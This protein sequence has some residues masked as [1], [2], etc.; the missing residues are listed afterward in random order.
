MNSQLR[1][2]TFQ[3]DELWDFVECVIK[4]TV[5]DVIKQ[6]V[7]QRISSA[8]NSNYDIHV[9]IPFRNIVT[10]YMLITVLKDRLLPP[11]M[12]F[13]SKS[14]IFE[15]FT[16]CFAAIETLY[17]SL[18]TYPQFS[19]FAQQRYYMV[20]E[21]VRKMETDII[22]NSIEAKFGGMSLE[23][24]INSLMSKLNI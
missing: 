2:T 5:Q 17:R 4:N 24:N 9:S 21:C 20:R 13:S 6:H 8:L 10:E 23:P 18:S 7:Y 14:F 3:F 12:Q 15:N 1:N 11:G 16:V 22:Y 19:S